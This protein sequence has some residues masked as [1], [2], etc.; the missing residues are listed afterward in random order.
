MLDYQTYVDLFKFAY[1]INR[2]LITMDAT[3]LKEVFGETGE[4]IAYIWE[5]KE[6]ILAK[7]SEGDRQYFE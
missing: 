5:N 1:A 2:S 4:K 7:L 3:K 6:D